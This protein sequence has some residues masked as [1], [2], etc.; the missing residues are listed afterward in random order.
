[1]AKFVNS[2]RYFFCSDNIQRDNFISRLFG[3]F[4]EEIV[5]YWC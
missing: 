1:M 2:F 3:I 4:N 5:H